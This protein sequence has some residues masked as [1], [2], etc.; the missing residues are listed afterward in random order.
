M[1]LK[2]FRKK[3]VKSIFST[4]E[5]QLVAFQNNPELTN[6]QLHQ[7]KK[8]GELIQLKRGI[9]MFPNANSSAAQIANALYAP[10]YISLEYAL[11]F[12]GILPEAAFVYTLVT[13]KGTR[14]F[15]TPLGTFSYHKIKRE[16]FTGFDGKTLMAEPEKALVDYFYLR[17]SS[18]KTTEAFWEESRLDAEGLDFQKII[19]YAGLFG[20]KK[21]ITLL[22]HFQAYAKTHSNHSGR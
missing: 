4:A 20:S 17:G 21:L 9:Y 11:S 14:Q 12:Y 10:C 13:P 1:K 18:F 15:V 2:D 7:W 6:L 8:Q 3:M 16:A 22:T 19:Q 5:A